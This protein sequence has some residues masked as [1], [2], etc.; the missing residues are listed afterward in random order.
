MYT[1]DVDRGVV[2]SKY[3]DSEEKV[4]R[5][6]TSNNLMTVIRIDY[7]LICIREKSGDQSWNV[8]V[9]EVMALQK[10]MKSE[11]TL[12]KAGPSKQIQSF[13]YNNMLKE[14][15]LSAK[16]QKLIDDNPSLNSIVSVHKYS[17]LDSIPVKIYDTKPG[18]SGISSDNDLIK[19]FNENFLDENKELIS[20][21]QNL[22][23]FDNNLYQSNNKNKINGGYYQ[24]LAD[25]LK[26]AKQKIKGNSSD[27]LRDKSI[28]GLLV[29]KFWEMY[30]FE[31]YFFIYITIIFL[32]TLLVIF[33]TSTVIK[34]MRRNTYLENK[35]KKIRKMSD[36]KKSI[37][38]PRNNELAIKE[39]DFSSFLYKY[40]DRDN[41]KISE[42]EPQTALAKYNRGN[43]LTNISKNSSTS[44]F[45]LVEENDC[46]SN[47]Q[48]NFIMKDKTDKLF[49]SQ[50]NLGLT[51]FE[52]EKNA[53]YNVKFYK[54]A[55]GSFVQ[56]EQKIL[57]TKY[58]NLKAVEDTIKQF[59]NQINEMNNDIRSPGKKPRT[60]S[61]ENANDNYF[62]NSGSENGLN[63]HNSHDRS[64]RR[65]KFE[66]SFS[67]KAQKN[68]N[69]T[70]ITINNPNLQNPALNDDADVNN[71]QNIT[72]VQ[73]YN[74]KRK[75]NYKE[76]NI[77]KNE[78]SK[79]KI[80]TTYID[81]GRL[82][83]NFE[84][85]EKIGQGGFG[86]VF[87]ARHKIDG[88]CYAVKMIELQVRVTQNLMDQKVIKEVK[89]MMKLNHK[90]VVRYT[91]CWFQL[92]AGT[93]Q[94][95][96][97]KSIVPYSESNTYN[98][99]SYS[100]SKSLL[101][102]YSKNK[103]LNNNY[104]NNKTRLNQ[105]SESDE[106][107]SRKSVAGFNWNEE[108]SKTER[109]V[110]KNNDS[111]VFF[112]NNNNDTNSKNISRNRNFSR[113]Q[114][115]DIDKA[116]SISFEKALEDKE[117]PAK[118]PF[119]DSIISNTHNKKKELRYTVYFF[120]QMEYCDGLPL[121]QYLEINKDRG[122]D[123]K[124][125]FSFFK[126]IVSGV[127]HIHKNNVIHRDLK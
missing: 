119:D 127:N 111:I 47:A 24:M 8:T 116:L 32:L 108:E 88:S 57:K 68:K 87:K 105:I 29:F 61:H 66:V 120:M 74:S 83:K 18:Q 121:N 67:L 101:Y 6:V 84:E 12:K 55:D 69:E 54:E 75:Y 50:F 126:Q 115:D 123:R 60:F 118:H 122:M 53:E 73:I 97:D 44:E 26:W 28:F 31:D 112:D 63:N 7:T 104:H 25:Y 52:I 81:E 64:S 96:L 41:R 90:N 70:K 9:S 71:N 103:K 94:E 48:C 27:I 13:N 56:E 79:L 33:L 45:S 58:E 65:K 34:Y 91:T 16:L 4:L 59:E 49:K 35:V 93:I 109:K 100:K 92:T 42:T 40:H 30:Y 117:D 113:P 19:Y 17:N 43:Y 110:G 62:K 125:I 89:T 10:G 85:I 124:I 95:M 102:S 86:C 82:D 1:I 23:D 21:K 98:Q 46:L 114:E 37:L 5:H 36:E 77:V 2:V 22:T 72:S 78:E 80:N 99:R 14:R 3:S 39:I 76:Y 15:E 38:S 106:K 11:V 20:N 107:S 51:N